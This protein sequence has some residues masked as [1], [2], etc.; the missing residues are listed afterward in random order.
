[1]SK[2]VN[3]VVPR[4]IRTLFNLGT[5]G[6]WTDGQLLERFAN[7][8][9]EAAELAFAALIERHGPSVFRICRSILRGEHDAYDAFQA[10]FLV[11]VRKGQT[12]WVRDSLEPWLHQVA[13]RVAQC[14]KSAASRRRRHEGLYAANASTTSVEEGDKLAPQVAPIIHE[15]IEQLPERYRLVV[16]LCDL[17]GGTH[18]SV[19]RHLGWPIGTV[20]SRLSRGRERLRSRL[21]RRGVAP[22]A[23][24]AELSSSS[25]S[26]AFDVPTELAETT[27]RSATQL[28]AGGTAT[29]IVPETVAVLMKGA[30]TGM[31]FSKMKIGT[32]CILMASVITTGAVVVANQTRGPADGEA[33]TSARGES[34][35]APGASQE[36]NANSDDPV[37]HELKQLDFDLLADEVQQLRAQVEAALRQKIRAEREIRSGAKG[38]ELDQRNAAQRRYAVARA[39]YLAKAREW[40]RE[41][42]RLAGGDLSTEPGIAPVEDRSRIPVVP[43][44]DKA[45]VRSTSNPA[46]EIGSV[47]ID[48]VLKRSAWFQQ[49][50][51]DLKDLAQ[52]DQRRLKEL[53]DEL[54]R[55]TIK[56]NKFAAASP[57][58]RALQDKIA[59]HR[60]RSETQREEAQQE[61]A[62]RE[63]RVM[64][65]LLEEIQTA[66]TSVAKAKGLAYVVKVSPAV[67]TDTDP[68][69]VQ[70]ALGR[71]V[72]YADPQTDITE[73]IIQELNRRSKAAQTKV[74]TEE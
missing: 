51:R 36:G 5:I 29:A 69:A 64:S 16:I 20:K 61:L 26:K 14:A 41:K 43:P 32:L 2:R 18:E 24:L 13:Y 7:G 65:T 45:V 49:A 1:V 40:N 54:D 6:Q 70:S 48:A 8:H 47:D 53:Q 21:L 73:D 28:A 10:T 22:C 11:L 57:D 56:Q 55:L 9:G 25:W 63:A 4:Q 35:V 60:H 33:A 66:I 27:C 67:P 44:S 52:D 3:R 58:H 42:Q 30:L 50:G 12:L 74:S 71:A 15:E 46:V 17:G 59:A 68:A 72:V 38:T 62:R 34:A 23:S 19:A 37:A 39:A 31:L